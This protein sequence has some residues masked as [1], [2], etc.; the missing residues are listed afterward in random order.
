[1]EEKKT[2]K[3]KLTGYVC[4]VVAL[5]L[6]ILVVFGIT[7]DDRVQVAVSLISTWLLTGISLLTVNAGKQLGGHA[8][9]N[10]SGADK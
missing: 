6:T 3:M 7:P 10:L 1:M 4:I 2:W 9:R 8:V 5:I